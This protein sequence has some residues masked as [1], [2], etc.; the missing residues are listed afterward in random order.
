MRR[1][2]SLPHPKNPD[3]TEGYVT[4]AKVVKNKLAPPFEEAKFAL[5]YGVGIRE[6]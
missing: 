1:G 2:A 4:V 3:T 6:I 5:I